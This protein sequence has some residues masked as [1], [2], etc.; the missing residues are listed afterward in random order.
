M[1]R[2]GPRDDESYAA[3][4]RRPEYQVKRQEHLLG[5]ISSLF[6]HSDI[7]MR[8]RVVTGISRP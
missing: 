5:M 8:S 1:N 7:D 4:D 2:G 3:A 6:N